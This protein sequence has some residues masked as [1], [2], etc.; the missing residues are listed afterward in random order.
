M[1]S[2]I[3][4]QSV[5]SGITKVVGDITNAKRVTFWGQSKAVESSETTFCT[6]N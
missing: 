6:E 5:S 4:E 1:G 2:F 3:I